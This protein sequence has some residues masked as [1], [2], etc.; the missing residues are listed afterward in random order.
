MGM[1]MLRAV[2]DLGEVTHIQKMTPCLHQLLLLSSL[3][4]LL[5]NETMSWFNALTQQGRAINYSQFQ[6]NMRSVHVA[7][8]GSHIALH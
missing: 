3:E 5:D 4:P 2:S 7:A 6:W 1:L 8:R